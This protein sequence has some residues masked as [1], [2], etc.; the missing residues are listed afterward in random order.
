VARHEPK[1]APGAGVTVANWFQAVTPV[2][3]ASGLAATSGRIELTT[4][5]YTSM[6]AEPSDAIDPNIYSAI[7]FLMGVYSADFTLGGLV[8]NIDLLGAHGE[9]LQARAGYV[10]QDRK[11][12]RVVDLV[13]PLIVNDMFPQSA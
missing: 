8:R 6:L 10:N 2:A 3:F 11:L 9:P 12:F 1:A 13:T 5:F 4:R 7:D